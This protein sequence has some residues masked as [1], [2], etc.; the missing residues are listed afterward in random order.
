MY[1]VLEEKLKMKLEKSKKKSLIKALS[2]NTI[3]EKM[4]ILCVISAIKKDKFFMTVPGGLKGI[5]PRTNIS[6]WLSETESLTGM[7]KVGEALPCHVLHLQS[8]HPKIILST[9]PCLV[10]ENLCCNDFYIGMNLHACVKSKEEYGYVMDV[11]IPSVKAFLR[12]TAVTNDEEDNKLRIGQLLK[13]SITDVISD[14]I[15]LKFDRKAN[16]VFPKRM[17]CLRELIPGQ[18]AT[19]TVRKILKT[20]LDVGFFN[21]DGLVHKS[22]L[23][24]QE[25][26][27]SDYIVGTELNAT[28]LYVEPLT[29]VVRFTLNRVLYKEGVCNMGCSIG[30]LFPKAIV[31]ADKLNK[32]FLKITHKLRAVCLKKKMATQNESYEINSKHRCRVIDMNLIDNIIYV[33]MNREHLAL[34]FTNYSDI[35]IGDVL[36]AEVKCVLAKGFQVEVN[37][38]VSGF[39][40]K[41]HVTDTKKCTLKLNDRV[42][43]KVLQIDPDN[44]SLILSAKKSIVASNGPMLTSYENVEVGSVVRGVIYH[45]ANDFIRLNFFNNVTGVV[46]YK[47]LMSC[48]VRDPESRF[49]IGETVSCR[50]LSCDPEKKRILLTLNESQGITRIEIGKLYTTC[51]VIRVIFSDIEVMVDGEVTAIL[52]IAHLSDI[53]NHCTLLN[54]LIKVGEDLGPVLGFSNQ[55]VNVVTRK[56]SF[57]D[58]RVHGS[59]STKAVVPC[60]LKKI[61][62]SGFLLQMAGDK[63]GKASFSKMTDYCQDTFEFL[64]GMSLTCKILK[65]NSERIQLSTRLSDVWDGN[66]PAGI[67]WLKNC[68]SEKRAIETLLTENTDKVLS[69]LAK[70]V[71]NVVK[72]HITSKTKD[73]IS[74][75][76]NKVHKISASAPN[77]EGVKS[78]V[79]KCVKA[80]VLNADLI[81]KCAD[82]TLITSLVTSEKSIVKVGYTTDAKVILITDE[83]VVVTLLDGSN[84]LAYLPV[85][86]HLN[87]LVGYK[88]EYALGE[89]YFVKIVNNEICNGTIAELHIPTENTAKRKRLNKEIVDSQPKKR[90]KKIDADESEAKLKKGLKRKRGE[91]NENQ[92][93]RKRKKL[94]KAVAEEITNQFNHDDKTEVKCLD[95]GSTFEWIESWETP[96]NQVNGHEENCDTV[97]KS[98]KPSKKKNRT[99]KVD[100]EMIFMKERALADETRLPET[101]DEFDRLVLASPDSSLVWLQYASFHLMNVQI[102]KAR[103]MCKRALSIINF[104]EE[105][106]RLNVWVALLN[107]ENSYGNNESF[108]ETLQEAER[109]NDLLKINKH[110]I[111]M[112]QKDNKIEQAIGIF[113]SLIKRYKKD[114]RIWID[115]V[116]FLMETQQFDLARVTL[117][118]CAANLTSKQLVEV[119]TK[120]GHLEFKIGDSE[121]GRT[122]FE[123]LLANHPKRSDLWSVFIDHEVSAGN[124]AA[125]RSLLE[126]AISINGASRQMKF[127]FK[128][129]F[130]FEKVHGDARSIEHVKR[131]AKD[132]IGSQ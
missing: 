4:N 114:E 84:S 62:S 127:L 94:K 29:K 110:I 8:K 68:L 85:K 50:V 60:V 99:K 14:C 87:D 48:G 81:S 25:R 10:N 36:L 92:E 90:Q 61:V 108:K 23:E 57:I 93:K 30:D 67:E 51:E 52:P 44:S 101:E 78:R 39:I 41:L 105:Q 12:D 69:T 75:Y 42:K 126:R 13:C 37:P 130:E 18:R 21:L 6:R 38:L 53:P 80:L 16:T 112:L 102:D 91:I 32:V 33:S 98:E 58:G 83:F 111:E 43:C 73:I 3:K 121:R 19:V 131:K 55:I 15:Q 54:P 46:R 79:G 116:T 40:P 70:S 76:F 100:D 49:R 47:S 11:G 9:D 129:Y 120:M 56:R 109:N 86:N 2:P 22:H 88:N 66:A 122:I 65:S 1:Y 123:N 106:E 118:R 64:Q 7:F 97:E 96:N 124:I 45:I 34:N 59:L 28:I 117:T 31:E 82:L 26:V 71:N 115:Y 119:T 113:T 63:T 35:K 17:L 20:G 77:V 132:Y 27:P 72:F 74:G 107:L 95:V 125:A 5:L 24:R 104:R 89:V 103:A 128:K